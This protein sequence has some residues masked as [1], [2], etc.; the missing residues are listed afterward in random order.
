MDQLDVPAVKAIH[1]D[2]GIVDGLDYRGVDVIA[3]IQPVPDTS[4][5][6]VA[7]IDKAEALAV[8]RNYASLIVMMILGLAG[9]AGGL[10]MTIWQRDAKRHYARIADVERSKFES[11]ERHRVTLMSV[12]DAVI[13]TD[14]NGVI[15][16]MNPVAESVDR[17]ETG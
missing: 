7:K 1:G 3:A 17:L 14:K 6:M 4:W 16:L 13:V 2:S 9:S 15:Q 5:F 10:G 11:E 12:G 8:W